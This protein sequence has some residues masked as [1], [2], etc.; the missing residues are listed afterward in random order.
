MRIGFLDDFYRRSEY[1]PF[2]RLVYAAAH[3]KNG[4]GI[5][6]DGVGREGNRIPCWLDWQ[7]D[8]RHPDQTSATQF[9]QALTRRLRLFSEKDDFE[10]CYLVPLQ[11]NRNFEKRSFQPLSR[12]LC[13]DGSDYRNGGSHGRGIIS[14]LR[15]SRV[16]A[17]NLPERRNR[18][19]FPLSIRFEAI[20]MSI[21]IL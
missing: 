16:R 6:H 7:R 8:G 2:C 1:C 5:G 17:S 12:N 10:P 21:L 15:P 4:V 13:H 9:S 11:E 3:S 19:S 14:C 20:L 18:S